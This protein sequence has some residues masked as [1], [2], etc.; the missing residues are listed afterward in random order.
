MSVRP[1]KWRGNP[2]VERV[3]PVVENQTG[4]AVDGKLSKNQLKK[5]EKEKQ[6][7]AKK[8]AKAAEKEAAAAS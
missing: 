8:A 4:D 1:L 6:I 5:L 2:R 7:A 3:V